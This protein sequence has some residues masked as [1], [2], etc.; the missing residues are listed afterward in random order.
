MLR[1]KERGKYGKVLCVDHKN[2]RVTIE[3]INM[4]KNHI[5]P[6]PNANVQGGIV[7]KE[8]SLH[9]SNVAI[10]NRISKKSDKI[11]FKKILDSGKKVRC[12]KSSGELVDIV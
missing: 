6:N 8:A 5:K 11:V 3:S 9:V 12:F 1:G 4:A 2:L 10:Y 7:D